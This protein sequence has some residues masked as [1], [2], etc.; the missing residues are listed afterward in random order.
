MNDADGSNL[1]YTADRATKPINKMM[2]LNP[3]DLML[4]PSSRQAAGGAPG[5]WCL[6]TELR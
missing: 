3:W 1:L 2:P 5:V 6:G 4:Q